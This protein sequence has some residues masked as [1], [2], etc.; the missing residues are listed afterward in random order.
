MTRSLA[1]GTATL[2]FA[3]FTIGVDLTGTL[4]L[5]APIENEFTVD[6]TTTQWVL[7]LYALTYAVLMITG[8]RLGDMYGRRRLMLIATALFALASVGCLLAPTIGWL[9]AARGVQG[10]GAAIM[11]PCIMAIGANLVPEERRGWIMGLIL[12]GVTSGNV[13]GPLIGGF[14]VWIGDWRL[15]FLINLSMAIMV[16]LLVLRFLPKDPP[17]TSKERVDFAGIAVLAGALGA[18]L[19]GLDVGANWG[20]GSLPILGIFAVSVALFIIFPLTESRVA[21]PMVP[22]PLMRNGQFL[23]ALSTNGLL[24]PS[25]FLAFLYFPQY[26]QKVLGW[27]VLE[28]SFGML[29]LMVLLSVGAVASGQFYD[30]IGPKRLLL[31]GYCL[32]VFACAWIAA[33]VPS[34]GYFALVPAMVAL[35]LGGAMAVGSA[36]TVAVSA[37]DPSRTGAAGGLSFTAHLASGAV[38]VAGG[39]AIM[40][41]SSTSTLQH[42]LS[43]AGISMPATEQATLNAAAPG[44]DAA[45]KILG[46]YSAD[47]A[48]KIQDLMIAGFTHGISHAYWLALAAAIVGLL[49]VIAI[50]ENKLKNADGTPDGAGG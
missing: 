33:L 40:Y 7:N 37:V 15:F 31:I 4:L 13:F 46:T 8:G 5:A 39:T 23:M 36:G 28:A 45:A 9:I 48:G 19:Y 35:G 1:F 47:T 16:A 21:D 11:W 44:A 50:D 49:I 25:I 3:A 27:S 42:G 38:G 20:W 34:W 12:A 32:I 2:L 29:P 24:V 14:V 10:A 26:F 22:P 17:E 30:S 6:I 18:L 43:E 41:A